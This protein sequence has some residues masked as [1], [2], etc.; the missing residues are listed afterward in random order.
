MDKDLYQK[1]NSAVLA[2]ARVYPRGAYRAI[3]DPEGVISFWTIEGYEQSS[4]SISFACRG[5]VSQNM[6]DM[7]PEFVRAFVEYVRKS[8]R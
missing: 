2:L 5:R 8:T 4:F 1:G 3:R 6:E 7:P